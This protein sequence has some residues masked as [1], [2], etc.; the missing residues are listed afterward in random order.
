LAQARRAKY[1][2]ASFVGTSAAS[3]ETK[4]QARLRERAL[5]RDQL[6]LKLRVARE[7]RRERL[8]LIE[9]READR[10]GRVGKFELADRGT[11]FLDEIGDMPLP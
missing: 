9:Q 10:K 8:Q 4:R 11:L 3:L 6:L 1:T 5:R 7:D 2:F